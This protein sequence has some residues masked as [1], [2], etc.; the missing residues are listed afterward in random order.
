MN[1]I[2]VYVE[3]L[4]SFRSEIKER[5][6]EGNKFFVLDGENVILNLNKVP[7][8]Y[9]ENNDSYCLVRL[10]NQTEMQEFR[11]LNSCK[12]VGRCV[13]NTYEFNDGELKK[14]NDITNFEYPEL[15][16]VFF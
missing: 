16:G 1:D 10:I 15:L 13:N 7:V 2:I 8:Y 9:G 12:E 11:L 5:S 4:T 6:K 14:F 3:D